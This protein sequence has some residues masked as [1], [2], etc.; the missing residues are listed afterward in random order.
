MAINQRL[1]F[2]I[3]KR[4]GNACRYCGAM[5]PDAKLTIDHVMPV[6]LGG[7]DDSSNLVTACRDCNAGKTS[8]MPDEKVVA[9]VAAA[10]LKLAAALR[11]AAA[12]VLAESEPAD[13]E[14]E[15]VDVFHRMW[16]EYQTPGNN[17]VPL[18]RNWRATVV[19]WR[20]SG[21]SEELMADALYIAMNAKG[22]T[23]DSV[24]RYMC[25]VVKNQLRKIHD[26]AAQIMAA[27]AETPSEVDA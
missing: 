3:L 11:Q 17:D 9:D 20:R 2:E 18:P 10:D 13:D 22:V 15:Y 24:F 23:N 26:R 1:R 5:A 16:G 25:G 21:L 4:D 6:A 8:T 27:T 7:T 12:E 14:R 19:N